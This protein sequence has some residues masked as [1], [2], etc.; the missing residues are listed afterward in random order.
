M[1]LDTL[2]SRGVTGD[3]LPRSARTW[4]GTSRSAPDRARGTRDRATTPSRTRTSRSRRRSARDPRARLT[5][6]LFS[7]RSLDRRLR[8]LPAAV[9]RGRRADDAD[10]LVPVA[11]R[12]AAA[13]S[14]VGLHVD[15]EDWQQPCPRSIVDN[16]L[17]DRELPTRHRA[18]NR[19]RARNVVLLH[20]G[21][22][23][24]SEHGR[25]RWARSSIRCA[26][27]ATRSC[28]SRELAGITRDEAM[29]PMPAVGATRFV[30]G[31]ARL[32]ARRTRSRRLLFWVFLRR[33]RCSG[34]RGSL[35][36]GVLAHRAADEPIT[37]RDTS[38]AT[39]RPA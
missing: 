2:R 5:T 14:T 13:T 6:Q 22:G 35:F 26:R 16:V 10:E 39:T 9:L 19:T 38:P 34:S 32:L 20:D 31:D 7:R 1:I 27:A 37:R 29:P 25:A 23:N 12:R 18:T 15:S 3:V 8:I 36:I 17:R 4:S 24:R 33:R 11:S 21:G 28:C 30:H